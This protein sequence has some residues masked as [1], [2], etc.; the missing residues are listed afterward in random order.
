MMDV[1][2]SANAANAAKNYESASKAGKSGKTGK[3]E[4]ASHPSYMPKEKEQEGSIT[5]KDT[6]ELSEAAEKA[7]ADSDKVK[8]NKHWKDFDMDAFQGSIRSTL[9]EAI[10]KAKEELRNAGVEFAKYDSD[11]ILYDLS[12]L[13]DGD[14]IEAAEVP[15]YWNAENTSQRIVDFAMSFRGLATGLS[16]EEYIEQMRAA[17]Q[18]GYRLAKKAIGDLPGPSAKLFNDTYNLTMKK[19]DDILEQSKKMNV[20]VNE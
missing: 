16:D 8:G 4:S 2:T 12:E 19:F 15:E 5:P 7:D 10:Y 13:K 1:N 6:V 11:S 3:H 20:T 14:S 18:E 9:M 17:V